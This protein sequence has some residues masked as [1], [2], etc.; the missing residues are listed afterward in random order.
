MNTPKSDKDINFI[1]ELHEQAIDLSVLGDRAAKLG[2]LEQARIHYKEA[3]LKEVEV[4]SNISADNIDSFLIIHRSAGY[5]ALKAGDLEQAK[6]HGSQVYNKSTKE[7]RS[8]TGVSEFIEDLNK[9][10]IKFES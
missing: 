4:I 8:W 3:Y 2:N 5:L 9:L 1:N 7:H 6:Y 10:G